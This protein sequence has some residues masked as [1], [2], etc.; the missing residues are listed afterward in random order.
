VQ[1]IEMVDMKNH[2]ITKVYQL[3]TYNE[4]YHKDYER[5]QL[6]TFY[7][8]YDNNECIRSSNISKNSRLEWKIHFTEE[9]N[10]VHYIEIVIHNDHLKSINTSISQNVI[11]DVYVSKHRVC[12][13]KSVTKLDINGNLIRYA[14]VCELKT[15]DSNLKPSEFYAIKYEDTP[16]I[17]IHFAVNQ[18]TVCELHVYQTFMSQW[19]ACGSP[20]VPLYSNYTSVYSEDNDEPVAVGFEFTCHEGF[21]LEGNSVIIQNLNIKI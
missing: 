11:S 3:T 6:M 19:S 7:S 12:K 10:F 18:I 20:D 9:Q 13:P 2:T 1:Q 4:D 17:T 16:Y 8:N 21:Q 5:Y 15:L 14:F